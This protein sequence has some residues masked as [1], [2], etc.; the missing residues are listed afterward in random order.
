MQGEA[1]VFKRGEER[2]ANNKPFAIDVNELRG[3]STVELYKKDK[4]YEQSMQL[5]RMCIMYAQA[6]SDTMIQRLVGEQPEFF[7]EKGI[8][9]AEFTAHLSN[10]I[11]LPV[12]KAHA[13][14]FRD[15]T[16]NIKENQH[17]T[18]IIRRLANGGQ[19]FHPYL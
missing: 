11:C 14:Q 17:T 2:Q 10:N 15:T 19:K 4:D 8:S 6:Y 18:D 7:E 9:R 16:A 12:S 5:H 3:A 13:R 1:S